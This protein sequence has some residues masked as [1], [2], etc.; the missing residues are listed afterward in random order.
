M[1]DDLLHIRVALFYTVLSHATGILYYLF[2][3]PVWIWVLTAFYPLSCLFMLLALK[4]KKKK[5]KRVLECAKE[6]P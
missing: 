3:I 2:D 1:S 4:L 5:K 6:I